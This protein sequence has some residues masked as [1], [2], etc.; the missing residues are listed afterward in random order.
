MEEIIATCEHF[1]NGLTGLKLVERVTPE[2]ISW[3][4]GSSNPLEVGYYP[5]LHPTAP[6]DV[7]RFSAHIKVVQSLATMAMDIDQFSGWVGS[8]HAHVN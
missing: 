2:K 7:L 3:T 5:N 4:L 6:L 8:Q 1:I